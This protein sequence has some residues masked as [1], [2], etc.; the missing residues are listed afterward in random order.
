MRTLEQA[1]LDLRGAI[2]RFRRAIS[3]AKEVAGPG[4]N[5]AFGILA[6]RDDG[7]RVEVAR[8]GAPDVFVEDVALVIGTASRGRLAWDALHAR[9]KG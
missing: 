8:L 5:V 7:S 1:L 6:I 9:Q 3:L 2:H 4:G